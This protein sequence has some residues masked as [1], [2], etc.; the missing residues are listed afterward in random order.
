MAFARRDWFTLVKWLNQ[1]RIATIE[2]NGTTGTLTADYLAGDGSGIVGLG[3][4]YASTADSDES[5]A[6]DDRT[7]IFNQQCTLAAGTLT[8]GRVLELFAA[9]VATIDG[10]IT[11]QALQF[12]LENGSGALVTLAAFP[13]E[14]GTTSATWTLRGKLIV[15]SAGASGVLAI[16]LEGTAAAADNLAVDVYSNEIATPSI[17]TTASQTLSIS[18]NWAVTGNTSTAIMRIFSVR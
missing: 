14:A 12:K 1:S 7:W 17:D 3:S 13:L 18:A 15:R 4:F 6:S 2:A 8:Q 16:S 5:Q 10:G 11:N 9:G